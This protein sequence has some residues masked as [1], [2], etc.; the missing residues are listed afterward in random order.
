MI[1]NMNA[2]NVGNVTQTSP[3]SCFKLHW[4]A[5]SP[6]FKTHFKIKN[7]I[8]YDRDHITI[9]HKCHNITLVSHETTAD[10]TVANLLTS[11]EKLL[12][13]GTNFAIILSLKQKTSKQQN[14]SYFFSSCLYLHIWYWIQKLR[15][16]IKLHSSNIV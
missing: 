14:A 10:L 15:K 2:K 13:S 3:I 6:D 9:L 1:I 11:I 8:T 16:V 5:G 12:S 7:D 4:N